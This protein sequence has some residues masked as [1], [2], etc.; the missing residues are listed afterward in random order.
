MSRTCALESLDVSFTSVDVYPIVQVLRGNASLTSLDVR[1]V[2]RVA[3][4]YKLM[5]ELLLQAMLA[6]PPLLHSLR[7]L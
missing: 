6:A 3:G 5:S 7:R 1:K 4:Q 2:P